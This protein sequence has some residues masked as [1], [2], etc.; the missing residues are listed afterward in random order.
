MKKT[1]IKKFEQDFSNSF[2]FYLNPLR[3]ISASLHFSNFEMSPARF[4]EASE[5]RDL[6]RDF[7]GALG[8][9][10]IRS[11][12]SKNLEKYLRQQKG[13]RPDFSL[14]RLSQQPFEE[15]I[16]VIEVVEPLEPNAKAVGL[17]VSDEANRKNA[18]M[19]AMLT[20][21]PTITRPIQLVQVN[22]KQSSFLVFNP[23]YRTGKIPE[24]E[25]EKIKQF[26]G[27]SY[28]P[29]TAKAIVNYIE[30]QNPFIRIS[31]LKMVTDDG[32]LES[33]ISQAVEED[34]R[35]QK[36]SIEL[37]VLGKKWIIEFT[38][39]SPDSFSP[40]RKSVGIFLILFLLFLLMVFIIKKQEEKNKFNQILLDETKI[41]VKLATQEIEEQRQF[42]QK[43]I[44]SVPAMLGYWDKN[45]IN[46]ISNET[47]FKFF[48]L[49]PSQI[50][51]KSM[52][53]VF[54][55]EFE[56]DRPYVD[57]VLRGEPQSFEREI[58]VGTETK[59]TLAHYIPDFD[60]S[61][62][63]KGFFSLVSDVSELK[64][65]QLEL[66]ANRK[67]E[68]HSN[69]LRALGEMSAGIAHEINNPLGIIDANARMINKFLND[70]DKFKSKQEQII[71][72]CNRIKKI[73]MGL[74]KF[75]RTSEMEE[76]KSHL[77]ERLIEESLV[78]IGAKMRNVNA[79]IDYELEKDL[80]I[81]CNQIEL[82]QVL[83]NLISNAL[84]AVSQIEERWIKIR[85][86]TEGKFVLIQIVNSGPPIDLEHRDKLF[87]PFFTTKIV[88]SGTG[89]GLSISKGIVESHGG[90]LILNEELQ[91]TCFEVR[92]P[93]AV[94]SEIGA[95]YG[96]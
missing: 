10:F 83:V 16:F 81:V 23:I 55:A 60:N 29:V 88:G 30:R 94:S 44:N 85:T 9:G 73:T 50:Q 95:K 28:A 69:K 76:R 86:K 68:V 75:S 79:Q 51:N 11:V 54:G 25:A 43:T 41:K 26:F 59:Y 14:K 18:A 31:H 13:L 93:K 5:S 92:I 96:I 27:W 40:L 21:T 2:N 32:S 19:K 57:A 17:V 72:A 64:R 46:R 48:G 36:E 87:Q 34:D 62:E 6:Y 91:N 89:L 37:V 71:S 42:L 56:K 82:E 33:I 52:S 47:Y 84:D 66:D 80:E 63:V 20:G 90:S 67:N 12:D 39:Q 8:F 65:V 3:G 15:K 1:H 38:Y 74:R 70:P 45:L 35:V 61:G 4:R 58:K 53:V 77:L 24:S 49:T 78:L 22:A 7:T